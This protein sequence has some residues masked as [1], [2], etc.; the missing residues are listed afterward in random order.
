MVVQVSFLVFKFLP[1][2]APFF[3]GGVKSHMEVVVTCPLSMIMKK[4]WSK[5][6]RDKQIKCHFASVDQ[7]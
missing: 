6:N 2:I 4:L 1:L 3:F 5:I 7:F